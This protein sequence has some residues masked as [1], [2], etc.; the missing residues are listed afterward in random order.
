MRHEVDILLSVYNGA[1]YLEKQLDSLLRQSFVNWRLLVRDD[2]SR[3]SSKNILIHYQQAYPE[4][5]TLFFGDNLGATQSFHEL[6]KRSTALYAMFCDQ[7]DIWFPDKIQLML[8]T[9]KEKEIVYGKETPIL[10]FSD[11]VLIDE[12][13]EQFSPS[14]WDWHKINSNNTSINQLLL[15][16]I[17]TGAASFFNRA[18][19]EAALPI[20]A[21]AILHDW[22]LAQHASLFGLMVPLAKPTVYYRQHLENVVGCKN[23]GWARIKEMILDP[24]LLRNKMHHIYVTTSRQA[25]A[26]FSQNENLLTGQQ[27]SL[28]SEYA[29]I[30]NS[31]PVQRKIFFLKE[32]VYFSNILRNICL[33]IY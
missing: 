8:Q 15:E 11:L 17:V 33:I 6:L 5:I 27:R 10:V 31:S 30:L 18:L 14:F 12:K 20:P 32:K 2:G 28:L 21:E 26:L 22:W 16:N 4:K 23:L 7:D 24:K 29:N 25:K 13:D 19:I 3:D 9:I 1:Q